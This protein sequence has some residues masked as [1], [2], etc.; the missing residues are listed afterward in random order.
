MCMC[1]DGA[2]GRPDSTYQSRRMS[3][4]HPKWL[5][6]PTVAS[7]YDEDDADD[8]EHDDEDHDEDDDGDRRRTKSAACHV[9]QAEARNYD[10]G[11]SNEHS[12]RFALVQG[13]QSSE[14]EQTAREWRGRSIGSPQPAHKSTSLKIKAQE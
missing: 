1:L 3:V 13:T 8:N 9:I 2:R 6:R 5:L 14:N 4:F 10:A 7:G 12:S 11:Q